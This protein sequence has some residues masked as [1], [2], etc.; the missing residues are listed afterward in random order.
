MSIFTMIDKFKERKPRCTAVIVA[1]GESTRMGA[2]KLFLPLAGIPVLARTLMQFE[3]CRAV[4]EIIVVTR[5]DKIVP[6][7]D[8]CKEYGVT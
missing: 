8:L 1:A 6:V 3:L 7:A 2:D 5:E 4:S